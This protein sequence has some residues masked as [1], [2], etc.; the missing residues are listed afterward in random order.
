MNVIN[1]SLIIF[2]GLLPIVFGVIAFINPNFARFISAP[3]GP[4]LKA[5]IAIIVGTIFIIIGLSIN[6]PLE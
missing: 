1:Y 5:L 3:G 6:M 2:G 4:R